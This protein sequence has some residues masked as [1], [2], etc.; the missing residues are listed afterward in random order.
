MLRIPTILILFPGVTL[1]VKYLS[2]VNNTF[3][4]ISPVGINSGASCN[5][6]N[7]WSMNSHLSVSISYGCNPHFSLSRP[8][9]NALSHKA[10]A[11]ALD[12]PS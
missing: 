1:S 6:I 7:Y 4:G 9:F 10:G 8:D 5:L 3:L 12:N 11:M 2:Q